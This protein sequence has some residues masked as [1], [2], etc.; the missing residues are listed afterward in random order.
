MAGEVALTPLL[1]GL[2]VDALSAGTALVPR[3]KSAVQSLTL[4]ECKALAEAALKMD[5]A[6][7]IYAAC[8]ALGQERYPDLL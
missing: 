4:L 2:G 7:E 8:E 5:S 1:L 6:K 3:V